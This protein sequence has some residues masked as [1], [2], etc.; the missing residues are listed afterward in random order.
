MSDKKDYSL[1]EWAEAL[2]YNRNIDE[3]SDYRIEHTQWEDYSS[4]FNDTVPFSELVLYLAVKYL[5]CT[6]Q[7]FIVNP[8]D[9]IS[10]EY[11]NMILKRVDE[12]VTG[13]GY[14][15]TK[16]NPDSCS[17]KGLSAEYKEALKP[18]SDYHSKLEPEE[19]EH[20]IKGIRNYLGEY[21][22]KFPFGTEYEIRKYKDAKIIYSLIKEWKILLQHL[23]IN[24][25]SLTKKS[26]NVTRGYKAKTV[27]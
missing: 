24:K 15:Q 4:G 21:A 10:D 22:D 25:E 1:L 5:S 13:R 9:K 7:K 8:P 27:T 16:D 20:V 3:W 11:K 26:T 19:K 23:D 17:V 18:I 12:L 14:M 6:E 2:E